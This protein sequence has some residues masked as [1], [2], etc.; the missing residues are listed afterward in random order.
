MAEVVLSP[1]AASDL[2]EIF[3]YILVE[4]GLDAAEMLVSRLEKSICSL[5]HLSERGKCPPE[6]QDIGVAMFREIQCPPWR[7][8]YREDSGTIQVLAVLDGR[9]DIASLLPERMLR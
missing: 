3:D 4:D 1:E 6:L 7:I 5:A 2:Y 8:F 9:R